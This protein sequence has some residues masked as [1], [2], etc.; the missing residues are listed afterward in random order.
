MSS[1]EIRKKIIENYIRS[2]NN[3]EIENMLKDL[4][5]NIVFRNITNGEINLTTK[6]IAEFEA[7]AE[8]AKIFF[9]QRE[10]KIINLE[11]GANKVEVEIFYSGTI[12]VDFP[13]GLK[14]GSKI[15]L[16]GKS[17]FR[18]VGDKIIGIEDIS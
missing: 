3:F 9:S 7:Q 10:Q 6:G 5:E 16:A 12:A 18:F 2:Y 15:E 4:D 1:D 14:S 8:Q 13:D 11:F 17:I